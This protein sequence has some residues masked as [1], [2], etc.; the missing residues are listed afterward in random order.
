MLSR[1]KKRA[2]NLG[3]ALKLINGSAPPDTPKQRAVDRIKR[4]P[5]P[6]EMLQCP[7]CGG[8]EVLALKSGVMLQG[9]KA[10]GGT[11]QIVCATC[12]MKGERIVLA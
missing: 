12:F 8:R 2:Y 6:V 4:A 5:K 9:G 3:M 11:E 7:R 1:S 10:K